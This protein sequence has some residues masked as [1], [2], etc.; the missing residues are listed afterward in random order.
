M[1]SYSEEGEDSS[2][3]AFLPRAPGSVREAWVA[4]GSKMELKDPSTWEGMQRGG[5]AAETVG[6]W[7][8]LGTALSKSQRPDCGGNLAM[9]PSR[10][11]TMCQGL[12]NWLE[13][14]AS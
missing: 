13:N 11:S 9:G 14:E 7:A 8:D 1:D 2:L 12:E 3:G 5:G 6:P 4:Q 10:A